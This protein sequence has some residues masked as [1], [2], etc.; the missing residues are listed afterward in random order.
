MSEAEVRK[1][2]AV[3]QSELATLPNGS[4]LYEVKVTNEHGE[5][6]DLPF[7]S[8]AEL[9]LNELAEYEVRPYDHKDFGRT[10]T[11][12]PKHRESRT[13]KLIKRVDELEAQVNQLENS[14]D[15]RIQKIAGEMIDRRFGKQ[16]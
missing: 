11:L 6:I 5:V 13:T 4:V 2:R 9:T 15:A 1:L 14:L 12:I 7:R 3:E 10:F 8:F 16:F